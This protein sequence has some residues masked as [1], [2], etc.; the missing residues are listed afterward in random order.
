ME[1][2]CRNKANSGV[3]KAQR[4]SDCTLL[5]WSWGKRQV[6]R[7][8]D[9]QERQVKKAEKRIGEG[10]WCNTIFRYL[11]PPTPSVL[12]VLEVKRTNT[13]PINMKAM[14]GLLVQTRLAW[15]LFARTS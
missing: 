9:K 12:R 2:G 10:T 1:L 14:W 3:D 6:L 5:D 4:I 13:G 15:L 8:K 11:Q 7:E